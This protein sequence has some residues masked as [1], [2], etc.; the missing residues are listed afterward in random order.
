VLRREAALIDRSKDAAPPFVETVKRRFTAAPRRTLAAFVTGA[1]LA[2]AGWLVVVPVGQ[3]AS[4]RGPIANSAIDFLVQ[5]GGSGFFSGDPAGD[6]SPV[7]TKASA[8]AGLT[9]GRSVCVRLCD[10]F[11]FPIAPVSGRADWASHQATCQD[12]CPDA[13]TALYIEPAGSDKIEDAVSTSGAA[14]TALP[15]ALRSRTTFDNTCTCHR[16]IAH[17]YSRSLLHDL[18][19]R[20][21][22][23]IMTPQGFVVFQGRSRPPFARE[24]FVALA[25]APMSGDNRA[26]LQAMEHASATHPIAA[27]NGSRSASLPAPVRKTTQ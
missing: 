12:T 15:V 22:D 24:D 4:A 14:Y 1:A 2:A 23:T 18:T 25:Q 27:R 11:F 5:P 21:G 26:A 16:S 13:P 9:S 7:R 3:G 8:G 20:K 6:A 17:G 10:G 19:L